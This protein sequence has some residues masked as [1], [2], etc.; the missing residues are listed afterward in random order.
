[1]IKKYYLLIMIII[2][3]LYIFVRL[4][5]FN[6]SPT[7]IAVDTNSYVNIAKINILELGF[8]TGIKPFTL[9]LIIKFFNFNLDNVVFFQFSLSL[10]AWILLGFFFSRNINS[11]LLSLISYIFI[12]LFSL[13]TDI[14]LWDRILLSESLN[15]S[16]IVILLAIFFL[17]IK[18]KHKLLNIISMPLLVL[19]VFLRDIN[20]WMLLFLGLV[21]IAYLIISKSSWRTYILPSVMILL[22]LSSNILSNSGKRWVVPFL[23]VLSTRI[24]PNSYY[25]DQFDVRGMPVTV[26][27]LEQKNKTFNKVFLSDPELKE[28]REWMYDHGKSVYMR[29]LL[30]HPSYF[31]QSPFE[32]WSLMYGFLPFS[33]ET[34]NDNFDYASEGFKEFFPYPIN[35]LI[36]PKEFGLMIIL[37]G[38]AIIGFLSSQFQEIRNDHS[39]MFC[40]ALLICSY[41]MLIL[42]YHGDSSG[43]SRHALGSILLLVFS[44]WLILFQYLDRTVLSFHKQ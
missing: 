7:T 34:R 25:T 24:L 16:L 18:N 17:G 41:P 14:I 6:N 4:A 43:I 3:I 19:W 26:K 29:F 35:E 9:P 5:Y 28:F 13:S 44:C 8:W 1:M 39:I 32:N 37:I 22:F 42:S 23:N 20:S 21:I 12:L 2:S 30:L 10:F 33:Q 15:I 31:L 27:L 38:V 11:L 36:Y 40:F